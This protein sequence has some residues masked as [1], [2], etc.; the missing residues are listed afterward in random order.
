[1][2]SQKIFNKGFELESVSLLETSDQPTEDIEDCLG[3]VSR[4][5]LYKWQEL[6]LYKKEGAVCD[7]GFEK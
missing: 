1:M 4:N 7:K 3:G 5:L 6:L 2:K